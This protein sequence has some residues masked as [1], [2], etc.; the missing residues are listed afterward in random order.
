MEKDFGGFKGILIIGLGLIG[1]SL[2]LGLKK[3][4]YKGKIYGYD[5][6]ENRVKTALELKAVDEGFNSLENIPWESVDLV[7]LST[8]V[9]TFLDIAKTIKP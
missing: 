9:K 4:G 8:P 2:A 5:L 7:V 1:G 6:N 3:E